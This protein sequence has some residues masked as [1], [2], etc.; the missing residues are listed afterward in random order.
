MLSSLILRAASDNNR[1][2]MEDKVFM[3]AP[4]W[5]ARTENVCLQA[6]NGQKQ[7]KVKN[8]GLPEAALCFGSTK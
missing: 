3:S 8:K 4:L 6:K 5:R 1:P 2:G 7:Q